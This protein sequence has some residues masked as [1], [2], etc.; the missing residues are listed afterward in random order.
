MHSN[1]AALSQGIPTIA[2]GWSYKYYGIM[3]RLGMEEYVSSLNTMSFEEL[4]VKFDMLF[5]L[6]EEIQNQLT[7]K[8]KDEKRSALHAVKLVSNL[9]SSC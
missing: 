9:L 5:S 8:I 4:K 7:S 6:R 2:I 3:K 1:I